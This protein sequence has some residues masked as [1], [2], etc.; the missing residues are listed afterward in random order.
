MRRE[1]KEG[2]KERE[3]EG[4]KKGEETGERRGKEE[5]GR[6]GI[7]YVKCSRL[8]PRPLPG[9]GREFGNKEATSCK[10]VKNQHTFQIVLL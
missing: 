3:G 4:G 8:I 7:Q 6:S 2:V 5:G 10:T 9:L 1:W